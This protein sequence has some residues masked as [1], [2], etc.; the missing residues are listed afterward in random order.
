MLHS[1]TVDEFVP[2]LKF[3]GLAVV[4]SCELVFDKPMLKLGVA[5]TEE[6]A[7]GA[8]LLVRFHMISVVLSLLMLNLLSWFLI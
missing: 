5:L 2:A 4:I 7:L 8:A 3:C 6:P 1:K